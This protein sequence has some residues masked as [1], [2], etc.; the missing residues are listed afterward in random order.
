MKRLEIKNA[1][2]VR[3]QILKHLNSDEQA[4]YFLRLNA[5]L[6]LI[7]QEKPNCS[8]IADLYG[9]APP[10]VARW[11][12]RINASPD[13]D[14]SVLMDIAKPGR[15]TRME[16]KQLA[17]ISRTLAKSPEKA[18]IKA[19]KWTGSLLSDYLKQKY[20]IELKIRMC[21]RWIRR[22]EEDKML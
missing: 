3:Q 1:N 10:T 11:V 18:G 8:L 12:N 7:E 22:F 9:I 17:V 16:E 14:I 15:N 19:D 2:K 20:K 6:M 5:I 4:K 21:Q 13:G